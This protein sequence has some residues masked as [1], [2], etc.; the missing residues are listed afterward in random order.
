M[1][2]R[3]TELLLDI[4]SAK[5]HYYESY[6]WCMKKAD[7]VEESKRKLT[8]A[9]H[10]MSIRESEYRDAIRGYRRFFEEEAE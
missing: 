8:A 9:E 6:K 10:E 4:Q 2:D 1:I 5:A 7:E 3:K